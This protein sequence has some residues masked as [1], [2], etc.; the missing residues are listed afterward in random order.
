MPSSLA[1]Q[2]QHAAP[3][4]Y[5]RCMWLP[6]R[7]IWVPGFSGGAV[8]VARPHLLSPLHETRRAA[9]EEAAAN[10]A[11]NHA[12]SAPLTILP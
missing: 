7:C 12:A 1:Q 11:A 8:P 6:Y 9:V 2:P 5:K 10:A 3:E 4:G